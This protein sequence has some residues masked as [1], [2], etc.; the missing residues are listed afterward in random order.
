MLL[1]ITPFI[2]KMP[3]VL[4]KLNKVFSP[5]RC[6]IGISTFIHDLIDTVSPGALFSPLIA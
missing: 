1:F 6:P 3:T 2:Q 4:Q 5:A